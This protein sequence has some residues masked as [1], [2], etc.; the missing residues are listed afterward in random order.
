MHPI[1]DTHAHLTDASFADCLPRVLE[2]A[3][4]AGL[5]KIGV[6]GFDAATSRH[7]CELAERYPDILYA[8]VGIQPNSVAE[9]LEGDWTM[10]EALASHPSVRALGE[11][12]LD[13]YWKDTP[14]ALQQDY[15]ERHIELS[16]SSGLPL[17]IHLRE[18]GR[19][20]V[21]QLTPHGAAGPING[22]MHSFTG[23]MA[24]CRDCLDLGLYIS[25]A[26]MVTF[27]KS[28]E[29]REIAAFVPA[30]RILI[31]TDSPY[32]SPEPHRGKRPNEPA[33]V[34]HTLEVLAKVRGVKYAELA[35]Q[36][37]S[38]AKRLFR[39]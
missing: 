17:V 20:I 22:V 1:I 11:T 3:R 28:D 6:I 5:V 12:G 37:T 35:E 18:T 7:A 38:N 2:N 4:S 14:F 33:R 10:V 13:L 24:T 31:E 27:K 16:K 21:D 19:E 26:G 34:V 29:L 39:V 36:T 32:L 9:A 15:F 30:D 23:D 8:S 25:F